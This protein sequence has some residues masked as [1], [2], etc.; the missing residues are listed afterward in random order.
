MTQATDWLPQLRATQGQLPIFLLHGQEDPAVPPATVAEYREDFPWI[1]YET[2]AGAG[3]LLLF[4]HI[5]RLL[6]RLAE[7]AE[8]SP[9]ATPSAATLPSR[10][11]R[12]A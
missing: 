5:D 6:D 2:I 11:G 7:I 3:Q 4:R 9:D 8:T 12:P 10:L 1:D